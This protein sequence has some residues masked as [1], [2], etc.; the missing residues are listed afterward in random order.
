MQLTQTQLNTNTYQQAVNIRIECFF[1]NFANAHQLI[2]DPFEKEAIHLVCV[3]NESKVV[4]TGRLHFVKN[5]GIISQ[6]AIAPKNQ[7]QGIGKLILKELIKICHEK[8][9][10]EIELSARETALAFYKK[11]GF[12]PFNEKYPSKKTGIVHQDMIFEFLKK[13]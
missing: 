11:F 1:K 9:I 4:G 12:T 6:M 3:D 2:N 7:K 5:T 10:Q 13:F 8:E